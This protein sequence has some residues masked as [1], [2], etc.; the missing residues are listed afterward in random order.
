MDWLID[1]FHFQRY[2]ELPFSFTCEKQVKVSTTDSKGTVCIT[3]KLKSYPTKAA[4]KQVLENY[5]Y[6]VKDNLTKDVTI[7]VNESGIA[8]AKTR[9]AEEMGIIITNNLKTILK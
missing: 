2:F 7:L 1:V 4:A 3:G 5:G 9:K 6:I 8:S